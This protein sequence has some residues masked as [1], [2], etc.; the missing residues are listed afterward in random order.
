M[1]KLILSISLF[2]IGAIIPVTA[3][4][5]M[6]KL[7]RG[8]VAVRNSAGNFFVSWRYFA[9]EPETAQFNLYA[10]KIGAGG[11]TK[12]NAS[13]LMLTNFSPTA[14]TVAAGTQLYVTQVL[15]G[16]EGIPSGIFTIPSNGFTTYRSAYLDVTY[17][18]ANDGLDLSKYST[19]FAWP[20]DLDGDGEYDFVVDRLSVDG[21]NSHKVQAYLRNGTLLWTIDVGPN[22]SICQGQ[23]DMVIAYDM[24]G[25]G[26]GD[27]VI[28]SSD[29]T[30]FAD[31]KGVNGSTSLDTDNDGIID[32]GTQNVKNPP[33]YITVI[34]GLTGLEKN[35]IEMKYP[36]NYTR[37]NKAIFMGE[38][39]SN[40]NGHMGIVYLDG[41]HPSVGFIYKTRTSS[42]QFH[43]Y[44]ASAYGYN[45]AGQ[46]TNWYNWE[47]GKLDAGEGHQI[48]VADVDLDGRD[49]LLDI[50]YGIKYDGTLAFNAH[51][52]HGDR[53]RTGDIDPE[54]PGL[55]TFAIGQ[56]SP[57]M[58]G[59]L[60]YDA[61]T[62]E[63]IKKIYLSAVGDVGRGECM[64]VDS[65]RLGYE[66]WSTMSN[67]YDAKGSIVYEGA[68]PFPN[69]G[70][71]WDGDLAREELTSADGSGF[72]AD[73]RKYDINTHDFGSRLIE[74]AKMTSWQ[75]KSEWGRRP[76][77][78]GDIAGDWREEVI[79][80]KKGTAS[81][82]LKDVNGND[83]IGTVETCPGFVGFSTDYA[84]NN[85]LYC[86]MQNPAY[87]MQ[88]TTR[89]YYQSAFPD[90][91]LGFKMPQPPLPPIMSAKLTWKTG[92]VL[93]KTTTAFVLAD[94]KTTSAFTD[95]DDMMFD[96]SG[97]NS[98]P[99]TMNTDM[100]PS[101]IW[102][103]NPKGKDYSISGTGK[104][105]GTMEF[106]KSMNGN[107]TLNG[108][109]TYTGKTTVYEGVLTVNGSLS[110][111]VDIRAK[112]TL[113]GNAVLNGGIIVNQAL[114]IEG[115]RIAPGNGLDATKLGKITIN[116]NMV[117]AGKTNL[118]FDIIPASAY[119]NDSLVVN[120]NLTLS[121]VNN[122]VI[123][124]LSGTLPSG[125]YSLMKWT[126]T[127]T[128][129]LANLNIEGISGLPVSLLIENNTLKLVVNAVRAVG[130][131]NWTGSE[132]TNW[133]FVSGNFKLN[134]VA[135][136]FV[137][138]DSVVVDNN[139]VNKTITANDDFSPANINFQNTS[140]TIT[141]KGT[142]GISGSGSLEKTGR[143]ILNI[144][145]L[146]N[147]Y[148]GK[149]L[150]TDAVVQVASLSDAGIAGS[151]GSAAVAPANFVMSNSRL[152]VN[153]TSTNT[154]RGLTIVGNDTIDILKSNGV[155]SITGQ[156]IGAGKLIKNGAGQLNISGS[157]ANTYTGGT[158]VSG[159]TVGLGSIVMNTSGL[160][161]GA[162]TLENGGKISMFYNTGDYNQK[163]TWNITIPTNQTGTLVA[164]GRCVINGTITG[165]GTLYF[166]TP[167]VRADL[168]ATGANFTGK[169]VVT[170]SDAGNFRITT[171]SIGFPLA[172]IHLA[173]TVDMSA[174]AATG[175]SSASSTTVVKI[176]SV[177]GVVG[178]TLGTGTWQIGTDNRD[179]V[180]SGTI[181][182]GATITKLGTGNWTLTGA[183]LCSSTFN[184][185]GGKLTVV[186][187]TGGA[188]G[189]GNANVNNGATLA[190]TGIVSGSVTVGSGGVLAPGNNAI[191]ALTIGANLVFQT[192]SKTSIEVSGAIND[193]ALV[194]GTILLKGT[195]EMINN[196]AAYQ[197][198]NAYTILT[199]GTISGAF[200]AISPAVPAQGLKWNTSRI[201]SGIISID[202][203][204]GI[205]DISGA[206]IR[207]YPTQIKDYCVVEFGSLIGEVKV[208]LID[209][210]GKILV[211][212]K[213]MS[214]E[215]YQFNISNL[216]PGFY[217]VRIT[218][219]KNQSFL[220]KVIK[221]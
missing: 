59:M 220:R 10:K 93:D 184:I 12:L 113:A 136:Y 112:G 37:T 17:N 102:A 195:L 14:G 134:D 39:Y 213:T 124:T 221:M 92:T 193:K 202:L 130:K 181:G 142:G 210:V 6:E 18:A 58:L 186:N 148:T 165:A 131:I 101:K 15:N 45:T 158:V 28:K 26:K 72:N 196:G 32:Y 42:D 156:I 122:I 191:G 149:T 203:A 209:Q 11:F 91:Y 44:Y 114:N 52:S 168:V 132:S 13:P 16:V 194:M 79:L 48:R 151:L 50:G 180:F 8:V 81:V 80:E 169:L 143:A 161:T 31:G 216:H 189:T 192:G 88:A 111:P 107:F 97:N 178:S 123:N 155:A 62:G 117:L 63:A 76:A 177:S 5:K 75:V 36:S 7:D 185:N 25:D 211:S 176:G 219:N 77:F 135:T 41:K 98:A 129:T 9:T 29:G 71:W 27:V 1:K 34:D 190:G 200:D 100:A 67:I 188:T 147:T 133:D 212:D 157:V 206:D 19:K 173:N 183:N 160:G 201:T 70:I 55:E 49:E 106:V 162:I 138:G 20:V 53:T 175:A 103:M 99:I 199:G 109:H 86:L 69:E 30:K 139:A 96:I 207:V 61:A 110:S 171:N 115:G 126:G 83:S 68:T 85:R 144:E 38:E 214:S 119:K 104:F 56:N 90:Y 141:L 57:S 46:L 170:N 47:R 205:E 121:G 74:F 163:P 54:R 187:T 118:H 94:E 125:T 204:D 179:A 153:A 218:S 33:Q 167:Y 23:D 89:G 128:G 43:W 145:T 82:T 2:L 174:Y 208:E 164:S 172:N 4:R 40:L 87:R 154:N 166:N 127:L 146:N 120:G 197:A 198:G 95:N 108:N 150:L 51:I 152:I 64:D 35:S 66:F 3:Q 182:S 84:S 21:L 159:G 22:V 24:D 65:T 140:G 60:T 116:S 137:T 73:I 215:N 217:F 105:T 78:F